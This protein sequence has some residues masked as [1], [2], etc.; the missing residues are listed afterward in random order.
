[1]SDRLR[2]A[3]PLIAI[4]GL[5]LGL[6]VVLAY[7]VF[8][9]A[10]YPSDLGLFST[11]AAA[12]AAGGPG[13]FYGTTPTADYP[14]GYLYILWLIG[15]IGRVV[16]GA[17]GNPPGDI[18]ATL[19]KT[20]AILADAGIAIVLYLAGRRWF[21][22]STGLIAAALYLFIPVTWYDSALWGQ[23]DAVGTLFV[24]VAVVLLVEG[25]SEPAVAMT[26]LAILVKPQYAI[27]L[28][29]IVPVLVRRH[30]IA[31]GSG[32]VPGL[33]S[34]LSR[35]DAALG[36]LLRRQGPIRLATSALVGAVVLVVPLLPFDIA[37]FA[38]ASL[39]DVPV[40]GHVAGLIGLFAQVGSEFSVLTANAYNG[41]AMYGDNPLAAIVGTP[42]A[43]WTSD[44]VA[45]VAGLPA[46]VVGGVL[47]AAVAA[48]I[49]G[50]L[51]VRD[52][53]TPI[54]LAATI[55][56][57]AF[58][59]LPTRVHERYLFPFFA[60]AALL[61]A[62]SL[63]VGLAY[64]GVGLLNAVNLHAVLTGT[65]NIRNPGGV[66]RGGSDGGG[67]FGSGGPPRFGSGGPGSDRFT[68]IHLPFGELARNELVVAAVAIGQTAVLIGLLAWWMSIVLRPDP[69]GSPVEGGVSSLRLDGEPR[70]MH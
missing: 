14:P 13:S 38:P 45:V 35:L 28:I 43:T 25:W 55:L 18:V 67:G 11:W 69:R 12:L 7:I 57:L 65:I 61:A 33:G 50:G 32:P 49:A 47:F 34:R 53:R 4:I 59:L 1:M 54:L 52:G 51:L 9:G 40:I 36:G 24:L 26:V 58:Y 15:S 23:I 31:V 70:T 5:G 60:V 44:S 8:P 27:A 30:L 21:G 10:G 17:T 29:V 19:L 42:G 41:W 16:G 22:R 46:V 39:A 64:V 2:G 37:T 3:A 56:A 63:R 6:R 48:V 62:S 20:P 66:F 68:S